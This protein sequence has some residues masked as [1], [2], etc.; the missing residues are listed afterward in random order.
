MRDGVEIYRIA[1]TDKNSFWLF[2]KVMALPA[3]EEDLLVLSCGMDPPPPHDAVEGARA[4]WKRANE[5]KG[6]VLIRKPTGWYQPV[7]ASFS[8]CMVVR[9]KRWPR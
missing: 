3:C 6:L 4:T 1:L 8:T 5:R 7:V 2:I 9:L